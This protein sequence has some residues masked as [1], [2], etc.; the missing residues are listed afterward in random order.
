M[1]ISICVPCYNEEENVVPMYER[2]KQITKKNKK[3]NFEFI[4]TDNK[5]KVIFFVLLGYL[6]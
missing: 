5:L 4:F 6:F 2:L 1:I 3:Y